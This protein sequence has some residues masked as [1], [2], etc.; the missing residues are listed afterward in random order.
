MATS[1]LWASRLKT[2][3]LVLDVI[4][5]ARATSRVE[6]A[7]AT[8]LTGATISAVVRELIADDLVVETGRGAPT[9]GK[10]RTVLQLN[11]QARY[12]VGVQLERNTC[13]I[14]VVD[15]AGRQ[16][17]RTSFQG[18]A[19]M[20]PDRTLPLVASQVE[21]LLA[22]A[23]V[24]REKV[25]GVGLVGYGPQDRRTGVLLTPQPTEEW[26]GCPVAPRLAESLGLPVL[27]DNDA[28]AAA[29]GEYWLGA[30]APRS[31]YGCI[32]MATGIGGGVVVAGEVYR[33][34]SSNS[35]EIGHISV[36]V[37]GEEC[38]CGN[39]GCLE[40]YAGP[41]AL[42]RQA[43]AMPGLAQRLALGPTDDSFLT[44]FARI[45]AAANAGDPEARGLVE[46]SARHLGYAAVTMATL[47]DVDT[48][49]LAGPSFAVAG[50]IYQAVIQQEVDRRT[51]ARRVHP[52][53]VVPS[54]NGSDAA[55]IGGAILVLQSELTLAH[56]QDGPRP[57]LAGTGET[58]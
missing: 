24:D 12:S 38:P 7:A 31:T 29:I 33:G 36:D 45:A 57:L 26:L 20:S 51:F 21:A 40:N 14:V 4:R 22:T 10:P 47:F 5:S 11:P 56:P 48:I 2:R 16:V 44:E 9:G 49:V 53:R 30:V 46:R 34:S 52:V 43:M 8:G 28:A 6:L 42:V 25:L 39:I 1:P 32:Y 27:L 19:E 37:N 18:T 15:L 41:S 13:V 35:V 17:A 54:V 55:A 50:S 58:S 3:G 23:A